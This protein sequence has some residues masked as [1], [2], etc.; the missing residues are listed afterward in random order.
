MTLIPPPRGRDEVSVQLARLLHA[1][2]VVLKEARAM[3][4]QAAEFIA[5]HLIDTSRR[6]RRIAPFRVPSR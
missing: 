4:R 5:E 2:E 6:A 1:H 3:A